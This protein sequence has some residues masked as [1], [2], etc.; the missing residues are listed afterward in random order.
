MAFKRIL[1]PLD[2][3]QLAEAVLPIVGELATKLAASV[4]LLHII[5]ANPPQEIHG[6]HHLTNAEEAE[7]YLS[8]VASRPE[9]EGIPIN[10]HV[11][12]PKERSVSRSIVAHA[13]EIEN[14]LI[15]MCTHGSG[16]VRSWILGSIAQQVLTQ[17]KTPILLLSPEKSG[18]LPQFACQRLL[19]PLDGNPQHLKGVEVA[20]DLAHRCTASLH[21]MMVIHILHT[22]PPE[23]VATAI[24]MPAATT[25]AL[26]LSEQG[27]IDYLKGLVKRFRSEGLK[28]TA[29]VRR[30]DPAK[31]IL[32]AA[33]QSNAD[34][35]VLGTHGKSAMDG[36]W[37]GSLTPKLLSRTQIPLLLVPVS[38]PPA[39]SG[40]D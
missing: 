21:L 25:E 15:V 3:S 9:L 20:A 1:V 12:A 17:G 18:R 33:K 35:I 2:G 7:A 36:F 8:Q 16:G 22:L 14:D 19:A 27:S 24:F 26:D 6:E 37:A 30:G 34:L 38:D 4:T 28:T 13:R 31:N 32:A 5:E 40:D 10:L 29:E 39:D 23:Q 11:H